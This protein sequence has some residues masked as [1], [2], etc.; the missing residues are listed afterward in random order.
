VESRTVLEHL[1]RNHFFVVAL[2][3][4]RQWYRYH[5]LFADFLQHRLKLKYPD[6]V[7]ELHQRTSLW[8][9]RNGFQAEAIS[10]AL[11]AQDNERAAE[12]VQGIAELL[13]WRRAEH[14]TLRLVDRFT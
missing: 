12:L 7:K 5:R 2:D 13:I 11:A 4:K 1:E 10:H 9:E 6:R 14:N 8:F 3:D